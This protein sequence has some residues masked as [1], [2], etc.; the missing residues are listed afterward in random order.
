MDDQKGNKLTI[1]QYLAPPA[2]TGIFGVIAGAYI[3]EMSETKD[4]NRYFLEKQVDSAVT[5]ANEFSVYVESWS[6]LIRLRKLIDKMDSA[7]DINQKEYFTNTVNKR[8]NSREKLFS[9][10]D[11]AQLYY[12]KDLSDTIMDFKKWDD[13][14]SELTIE[15]IAGIDR[16]KLWQNTI[17]NKIQEEVRELKK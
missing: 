6:R 4:T 15:N 5:I 9:A 13:A 12:S 17:I 7:P 8:S 1:I 2:I 3:S 16:W 10:L 14:Q 11:A